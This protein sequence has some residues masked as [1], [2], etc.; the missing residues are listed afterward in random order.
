MPAGK[1]QI[2]GSANRVRTIVY[3]L[4]LLL[5]GPAICGLSLWAIRW[6]LAQRESA[7]VLFVMAAS[8]VFFVI[9]CVIVA[10][11]VWLWH[12]LFVEYRATKQSKNEQPLEAVALT[13][14]GDS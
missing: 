11:T 9:G 6:S 14:H 8:L 2:M 1:D 7:L 12:E 5:Y 13:A 4:G 3:T 10:L